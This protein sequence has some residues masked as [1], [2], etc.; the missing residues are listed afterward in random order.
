VSIEKIF[1]DYR[2]RK[3]FSSIRVSQPKYRDDHVFDADKSVNW[4]RAEVKRQND[5]RAEMIRLKQK[6]DAELHRKFISDV[7]DAMHGMYSS[8]P[9]D[10]AEKIVEKLWGEAD[11]DIDKFDTLLD[12]VFDCIE[13]AT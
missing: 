9:L 2:G 13:I 10:K 12:I 5:I 6:E 1:A 3:Y 8:I 11:G 4:N 7:T